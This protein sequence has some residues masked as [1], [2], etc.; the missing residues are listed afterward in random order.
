VPD[1]FAVTA[2]VHRAVVNPARYASTSRACSRTRCPGRGGRAIR[3]AS[4]RKIGIGGPAPSDHPEFARFLVQ[5][6]MG[7]ISV[8]SD[9][10]VPGLET[11]AAAERELE[12]RP[13]F[14][15]KFR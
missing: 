10:V 13:R 12:K 3:R 1:G 9:A 11:I 14:V 6:E 15:P 5:L 2:D 8:N 7:G 4:G